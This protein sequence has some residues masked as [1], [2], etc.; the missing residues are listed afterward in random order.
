ML[1]RIRNYLRKHFNLK[2][3][4]KKISWK[5]MRNT[6][7]C[8]DI[9]Y[10][11]VLANLYKIIFYEKERY[12]CLN[13]FKSTKCVWTSLILGEHQK[14]LKWKSLFFTVSKFASYLRLKVSFWDLWNNMDNKISFVGFIDLTSKMHKKIIRLR[15][16]VSAIRF[17][18]RLLSNYLAI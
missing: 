8:L 10:S 11:Y 18:F 12:A 2:F 16:K 13:I 9:L 7:F 6:L 17:L 1:H 5:C 4:Y 3:C 14:L 15:S